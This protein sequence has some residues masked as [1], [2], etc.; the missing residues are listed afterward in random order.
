MKDQRLNSKIEVTLRVVERNRGAIRG[1]GRCRL[2][3]YYP[4]Q[5]QSRKGSSLFEFELDRRHASRERSRS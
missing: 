3:S 4:I 1:F 5:R 2:A